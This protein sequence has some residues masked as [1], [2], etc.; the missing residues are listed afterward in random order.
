ME[1]LVHLIS[2][3]LRKSI[4][5]VAEKRFSREKLTVFINKWL[6]NG[7]GKLLHFQRYNGGRIANEISIKNETCLYSSWI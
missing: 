6:F 5:F 1:H 4:S 2:V 7:K 3:T